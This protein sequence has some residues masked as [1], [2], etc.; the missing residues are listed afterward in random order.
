MANQNGTDILVEI[1]GDLVGSQQDVTFDES[2]DI[3]EF[4]SKD[5]RAVGVEAGHYRANVTLTALYVPSDPAQL[6]LR[7]ALQ[8]GSKVTLIRI[9]NGATLESC[10]AVVEG[11]PTSAPDAAPATISISLRVDGEWIA[12]S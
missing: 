2:N 4:T 10:Q 5:Q 11:M 12:G 8:L 7:T 6:A 3:I 9:E 1:D